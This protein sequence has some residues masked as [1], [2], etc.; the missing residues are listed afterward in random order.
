[1]EEFKSGKQ[2]C[3]DFIEGLLQ[4]GDIDIKIANILK[5]LYTKGQLTSEAIQKALKDLRNG[6]QVT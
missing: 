3:D 1:M 2:L 6:S 4:R 5:D